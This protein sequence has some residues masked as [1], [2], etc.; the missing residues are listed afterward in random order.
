MAISVTNQATPLGSR[1]VQDTDA[2]GTAKDNTTGTTGSLYYVE[3]VNPNGGLVYFKMA[4]TTDAT[5]GTTAA[6]L[7]ITC[8]GSAT[9]RVILPAG[10]AFA[11]GFSHW[12]VTGVGENQTASP[13]SDVTVRYVTS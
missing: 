1:I 8:A 5:S 6:N 2:D 11:A 3:V 13:S 7:V 9:T 10:I 12:C 4:D